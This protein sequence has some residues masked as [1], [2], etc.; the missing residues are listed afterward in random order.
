[1]CCDPEAEIIVAQTIKK[2]REHS[3][4]YQKA[5]NFFQNIGLLFNNHA[6]CTTRDVI[7]KI[8]LIP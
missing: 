6:H 3:F 4:F 8:Q 1:V 2:S 7:D 5:Q